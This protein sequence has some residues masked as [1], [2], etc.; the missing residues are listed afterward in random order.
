[1]I[2]RAARRY[3]HCL[4]A[5]AVLLLAGNGCAG[6]EQEPAAV[7]DSQSSTAVASAGERSIDWRLLRRSFQ[8]DARWQRGQR[9]EAAY[10]L[11]LGY[12]IDQKLLAQEALANGAL[13]D[14]DLAGYLEAIREKEM[15]K[16]L[17]RRE[18]ASRVEISEETYRRAYRYSKKKVQFEY[19][20][21]P[22]LPRAQDY[23]QQ[24]RRQ[25]LSDIALKDPATDEKG[26]SPM[27][28]FGDVAEELEPLVFE[29]GAQETGGP[30]EVDGNY[31]VVKVVDGQMEKFMSEIDYATEKSRIER[32]LFERR[33]E[34]ISNAYIATLLKDEN[35]RINPRAFTPLAQKFAEIIENKTSAEPFPIHVSDRELHTV[36]AQLADLGD[37]VLV[38]F[39]AGQLT[40]KDFL[41]RLQN[42]P[43]GIRPKVNMAPHL[44]KAIAGVVRNY[45]L[46]AEARRQGLDRS[47]EVLYE[48]QAQQDQALAIYWSG[49]I[50]RK[51]SVSAEEI[52]EFKQK[53]KYD[54][55]NQRLNGTLDDQRVRQI[56]LD[57]KFARRQLD[58]A[59]SLR[60]VY[61]AAVDSL[62]L[63]AL[64]KDPDE[65]IN[66][67][68][69][70]FAYREQFQ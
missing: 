11:Q 35:V 6:R 50:R 64:V 44:R 20:T 53:E 49:K 21:T 63:R 42:M 69:V 4:L 3:L 14:P 40:V 65:L 23:L 26:V 48:V 43:N 12:L 2:R 55:V 22:D 47:P 60:G 58:I 68:P 1:M 15:I 61:G 36:Q 29:L 67:Q 56:I 59:D 54:E 24:L 18:V 57:V 7:A 38:S 9:R 32:I 16:E 62:Q 27:F 28:G 45:Y 10:R 30:V 52:A 19:I 17:Y 41:T 25:P 13:Q 34:A 5:A 31:M 37:A 66:E 51:L 8:L 46:A 33:A 39:D 70:G